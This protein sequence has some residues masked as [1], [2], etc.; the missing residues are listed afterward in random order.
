MKN[1]IMNLK[2]VTVNA[3]LKYD[4][5]IGSGVLSSAGE[6]IAALDRGS[7]NGGTGNPG[8][9]SACAGAASRILLVSDDTVYSLYGEKTMNALKTAGF[10]ISSY[11]FPHGESSK[12]IE[13]YA[14]ILKRGLDAGMTRN[15]IFVALGGG[16]TGDLTG[17]A[18]ATFKRGVRF[19]QIPTTLLA[20]VDASVGGKTGIDLEGAKNQVGAFHQPSLVICDPELLK[21]LPEDQFKSGLAEV[22]KTAMIADENLFDSLSEYKDLQD[23]RSGNITEVIGGCVEIKRDFVLADEFDRGERMILNFGHTVGHGIEAK[24]GFSVLHGYAVAAGMAVVSRAACNRNMCSDEIPA[25]LERMLEKFGLP[26]DTD[27][28]AEDVLPF[29]SGDKKAS[30][31]LINIVVPRSIGKCEIV[32]LPLSGVEEFLYDGGL[33]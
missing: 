10:E 30:G 2:T 22:I 23:F 19:V 20:A 14:G 18:A 1:E 12:N 3:S 4:V 28:S 21:T 11:I 31:K 29:I 26:A 24:S 17:F 6:L 9:R 13:T 25:K 7:V 15:D 32:P 33:R 27:Y 8:V 5:V 16:V